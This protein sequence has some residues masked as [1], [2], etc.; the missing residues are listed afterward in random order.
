MYSQERVSG[1]GPGPGADSRVPLQQQNVDRTTPM[2]WFHWE[3]SR[4]GIADGWVCA[5]DWGVATPAGQMLK[6]RFEEEKLNFKSSVK[7]ILHSGSF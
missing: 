5:D 4:C 3:R 2:N 7:G 6:F 1:P